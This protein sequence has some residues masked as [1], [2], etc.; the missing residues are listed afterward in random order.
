MELEESWGERR[1]QG[2]S[3]SQWQEELAVNTDQTPVR[4]Q[5]IRQ[6]LLCPEQ[7]AYSI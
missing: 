7:V 2:E 1:L 4:W 5:A 3:H 6:G